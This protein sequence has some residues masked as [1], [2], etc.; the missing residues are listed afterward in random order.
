[1]PARWASNVMIISD[2]FLIEKPYTQA[3]VRHIDNQSVGDL[4]RMRKVVDMERNKI[5]LRLAKGSLD[6]KMSSETSPGKG[7][8]NSGMKKGG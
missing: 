8:A 1:M 5:T 4:E 6:G 2:T 3:N 7:A